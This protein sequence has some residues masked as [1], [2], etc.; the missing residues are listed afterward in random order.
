[1]GAKLINAR[2]E[3]VAEKPA[4]REAFKRRRCLIPADGFFEWA[5]TDGKKQPYFFRMSDEQPF[6]FAGLWERWQGADGEVVGSCAMLTTAANE[7][8]QPVHDRMP[9]ILHP[10]DYALWLDED[11]R[12]TDLLRELLQPY[13]AQEMTAYPVSTLVNS[14]RQQ[15]AG[16]VDRLKINSA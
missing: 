1:M 13:P 10:E 3:T 12:K 14:T 6:S 16:L 2:S 15:G 7:L 9:V 8:L 11:V 4:S 5:R